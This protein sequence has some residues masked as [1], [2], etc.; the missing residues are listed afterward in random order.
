MSLLTD[1]MSQRVGVQLFIAGGRARRPINDTSLST[2]LPSQQLDFR[3]FFGLYGFW[4]A[5]SAGS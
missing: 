2:L 1:V 4:A 5:G 3:G